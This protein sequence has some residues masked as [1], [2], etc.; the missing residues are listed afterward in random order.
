MKNELKYLFPSNY[1]D[2]ENQL[3]ELTKKFFKDEEGNELDINFLKSGF[4]GW[5]IESLSEITMNDILMKSLLYNERFF[6][7]AVLP[8]SIQNFALSENI[9]NKAKPAYGK[10]YINLSLNDVKSHSTNG[11]FIISKETVFFEE[12]NNFKAM[13]PYEIIVDVSNENNIIAYYNLSKKNIVPFDIDNNY[14]ISSLVPSDRID[15]DIFIIFDLV[16]IEKLSNTYI[17]YSGDTYKDKNIQIELN[18]QFAGLNVL[19]SEDN[20]TFEYLET[21]FINAPL[22]FVNSSK[23]YCLYE[24]SDNILNVN[25]SFKNG[26]FLPKDSS[27]ITVEAFQTDGG[28]GNISYRNKIKVV[29]PESEYSLINRSCFFKDNKFSMLKGENILDIEGLKNKIFDKRNNPSDTE[30]VLTERNIKSFFERSLTNRNEIFKIVKFRNDILEKSFNFFLLFKDSNERVI[31]TNS[32]DVILPSNSGVIRE[33]SYI[34]CKR[35]N[36]IY[37]EDKNIENAKI[38]NL[39]N[40][41]EKLFND[42]IEAS[43]YDLVYYSN[44]DKYTIYRNPYLLKI[45]KEPFTHVNIYKNSF[46]Y[47]NFLRMTDLNKNNE[48]GVLIQT[49]SMK[50]TDSNN[51]IDVNFDL[52]YRDTANFNITVNYESIIDIKCVIYKLDE[53]K[54]IPL[55][56]FK[57]NFKSVE[58]LDI[59]SL[60]HF[61]K[62]L[63]FAETNFIENGELKLVSDIASQLFNVPL[64]SENTYSQEIINSIN[65]P[66]E[67]YMDIII[68]ENFNGVYEKTN[69]ISERDLDLKT[70][71]NLNYELLSENNFSDIAK[72]STFIPISLYNNTDNIMKIFFLDNEGNLVLKNLPVVESS[73]YEETNN[74]EE[75]LI[76]LE[77]YE[78]YLDKYCNQLE[79]SFRFNIK[80][81]NTFGNSKY[82]NIDKVNI[83][84]DI[85]L[86]LNPSANIDYIYSDLNKF[87][88]EKI[89]E[90]NNSDVLFLSNL[91]TL[92]ENNFDEIKSVH[93]ALVNNNAYSSIGLLEQYKGINLEQSINYIPEYLNIEY[94]KENNFS[95]KN[96]SIRIR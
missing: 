28:L 50:K 44:K 82:Y 71:D 3:V 66:E 35:S 92:I 72:F 85:D 30:V 62:K 37:S 91:T 15:P 54:K 57:P 49:L 78:K 27:T 74:Y 4:L 1:Y 8:K 61:E 29:F 90:L 79:D 31:P 75:F 21:F 11:K 60:M 48:N 55:F 80:F 63:Y 36:S 42:D 12:S 53:N 10:A 58:K 24:I 64:K 40:V 41:S 87:I 93:I 46:V 65:I 94:N 89:E 95:Y 16:Q 18:K 47:D 76:N 83:N 39:N 88:K 43:E 59:I 86:V 2:V 84:M 6:N 70:I 68:G 33:G 19:Y 52:R 7:S 96:Y 81:F 77:F 20:K 38:L 69:F 23:E 22:S 5:T 51:Y 9:E 73:F 26:R 25:F 34:V 56:F 17:F 32:I 13:L 45:D 14:L 67:I